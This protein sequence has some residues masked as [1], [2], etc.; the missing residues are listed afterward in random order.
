MLDGPVFSSDLLIPRRLEYGIVVTHTQLADDAWA[1][2]VIL[3]WFEINCSI[4]GGIQ[5]KPA[6]QVGL[7]S[8]IAGSP[9]RSA[10]HARP[11][12][13]EQAYLVLR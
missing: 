8:P 1:R 7:F 12:G 2:P 5:L 6:R 10:R 3:I 9:A 13:L 4:T 11:P